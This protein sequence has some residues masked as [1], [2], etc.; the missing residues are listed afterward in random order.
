MEVRI[1]KNATTT[2]KIQDVIQKS[3]LS[4]N[5]LAK[6]YNLTWNTVKKWKKRDNIFDESSRP[7][8]LNTTKTLEE[9][10][11]IIFE[12]SKKKL[13]LDDIYCV[14]RDKIPN[15]YRMKVYRWIMRHNLDKLPE[16]FVQEE[17]KIKKFKKYTIG[18]LHN[19]ALY[20]HLY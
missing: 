5:A 10:D 4:I 9:E 14:L 17:R 19:K 20:I 8:K 1:H 12:R 11:L 7:N 3:K 16:E 15:L 2:L 13:S 6:K 18:F